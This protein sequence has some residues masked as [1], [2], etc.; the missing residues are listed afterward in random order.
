MDNLVGQRA[1][2]GLHAPILTQTQILPGWDIWGPNGGYV[3]ALA[4]AALQEASPFERTANFHCVYLRPARHG[5]CSIEVTS[6]RRGSSVEVLRATLLQDDKP[7]LSATATFVSKDLPGLEH[8][9]ANWGDALPPEQV[10]SYDEVAPDFQ[11]WP[12]YWRSV[13]GRPL[14]WPQRDEPGP[15]AW[16]AWLRLREAP[17][18]PERALPVAQLIM[19]ADIAPYNAALAGTQW[20]VAWI[21]PNLDLYLQFHE[22][23]TF[24]EWLLVDTTSPRAGDGLVSGEIRIWNAAGRLV[25][26]GGSQLMSRSKG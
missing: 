11:S 18:L 4:Y 23:P 24:G 22:L 6:L 12:R 1:A 2:A 21:A 17:N 8:V 5:P 10:A 13:E 15:A 19:W 3:A 26:A 7:V 16:R 25:S 9:D 14:L 20:P